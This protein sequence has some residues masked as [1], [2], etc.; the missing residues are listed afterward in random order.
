MEADDYTVIGEIQRLARAE[1]RALLAGGVPRR[2]AEEMVARLAESTRVG[3]E[4]RE[5]AEMALA[6]LR[7]GDL[8]DD[9][10]DVVGRLL[11]QSQWRELRA[12]ADEE[13][14][15]EDEALRLRRAIGELVGVI[16]RRH[17]GFLV[18]KTRGQA[19][20]WQLDADELLS[21]TL[22]L[23]E[24]CLVNYRAAEEGKLLASM[25]YYVRAAGARMRLNSRPVRVPEKR[26]RLKSQLMRA[27]NA[28]EAGRGLA[29][30]ARELGVSEGELDELFY[31]VEP[32]DERALDEAYAIPEDTGECLVAEIDGK[33][34][35]RRIDDVMRRLPGEL[36]DV[37]AIAVRTQIEVGITSTPLSVE[38]AHVR[39]RERAARVVLAAVE[40]GEFTPGGTGGGNGV[41]S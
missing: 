17:L 13:R 38:E 21:E 33:L 9:A 1:R 31:Q 22:V 8:S 12:E 19:R 37:A 34:L 11:S 15:G 39:L 3:V 26:V 24:R 6:A 16:Y 2:R 18:M 10:S 36:S 27:A 29:E 41:G 40:A 23:L 35:L 4:R 5:Q 20:V 25:E 30:I 14:V 32:L 7:A 28:D